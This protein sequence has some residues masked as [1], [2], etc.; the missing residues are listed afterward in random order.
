MG[1]KCSEAADCCGQQIR[2]G[3]RAC[4]FFDDSNVNKTPTLYKSNQSHSLDPEEV[5]LQ[6]SMKNPLS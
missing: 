5:F 2:T 6:A 3:L 4:Q 1:N